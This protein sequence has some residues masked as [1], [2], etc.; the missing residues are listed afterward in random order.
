[1]SH[2]PLKIVK[3]LNEVINEIGDLKNVNPY[4]FD[5]ESKYNYVFYTDDNIKVEVDFEILDEL[6]LKF[7]KFPPAAQT[8]KAD[9]IYNVS[10]TVGGVST[11]YKKTDISY[12]YKIIKTVSAILLDFLKQNPNSI[13][14][15]VGEGKKGEIG[16]A[17]KSRYY[18]QSALQNLPSG[19]R[20]GE[21]SYGSS[22]G[23]YVGPVYK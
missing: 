12:F 3:L 11:Q 20:I 9:R 6:S 1:M 22:K 13:L 10:Y 8:D 17:Q 21:V 15:I 23:I 14:T 2:T 4:D 5:Q 7:L 18:L 19:Y 16:D